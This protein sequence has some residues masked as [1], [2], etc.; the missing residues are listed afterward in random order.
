MVVKAEGQLFPTG[1]KKVGAMAGDY[2]EVGC[3]SVLNPGTIIGRH[4][5]IYP[6]CSVRGFVPEN[7]LLKSDGTCTVCL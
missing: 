7:H 6:L 4:G 2:A 3:N 5:R 1:R